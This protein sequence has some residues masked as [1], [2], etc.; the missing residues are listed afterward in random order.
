MTDQDEIRNRTTLKAIQLMSSHTEKDLD[1][2]MEQERVGNVLELAEK[3]LFG[4][5]Q[6]WSEMDKTDVYMAVMNINN[7]ADHPYSSSSESDSK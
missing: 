3:L 5:V 2:Y 4:R 6:Y 7:I 1:R